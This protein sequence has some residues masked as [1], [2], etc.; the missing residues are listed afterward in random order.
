MTLPDFLIVGSMKCGTTT[1]Y[2]DLETSPGVFFPIDKEPGHL[3]DDAVL[4]PGPFR[5]GY[6]ALFARARPDQRKGEASTA[7]T[8]RPDVD[9]VPGRAAEILGD[10]PKIIYIVREPVARVISQHHHDYT[11]G[12]CGGSIDRAV[13]DYPPLIEYTRYAWQIGP[14]IERFGRERVRLLLFHEYMA[15]RV[16]G[17]AGLFEFLGVEPGDVD[18]GQVF[19]RSEAKPV[20]KGIWSA[21]YHAPVY[22]RVLRPLVP[23]GFKEWVFRTMLPKAPPRPAPPSPETVGSI[24]DAV[25]ED[26]AELARIMG[27]DAPLWDEAETIEKHGRFYSEHLARDGAGPVRTA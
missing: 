17:A 6:E 27:R 8:K 21:I 12:H 11:E 16:A 25:R 9:G 24:L 23:R 13:R 4:E 18:A 15:D 2:R 19:N 14:W 5:E 3:A 22:R 7:Y 26:H 1:V 10:D 20:H